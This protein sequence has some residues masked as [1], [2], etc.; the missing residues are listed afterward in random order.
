M[1]TIL[2]SLCWTFVFMV[3]T[4]DIAFAWEYR[5]LITM[6]EDNPIALLMIDQVGLIPTLS[7]RALTIIF[8]FIVISLSK[9]RIQVIG[10]LA[11]LAAHV[12]LLCLYL[13]IYFC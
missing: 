5:E 1:K 9:P 8:A 12:Y 4:Y 2:M 10:S 7:F 6:W 11:V 3:T 13:E